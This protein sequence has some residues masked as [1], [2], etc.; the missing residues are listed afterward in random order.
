MAT[1]SGFRTVDRMTTSPAIE[2]RDAVCARDFSTV[3]ALLA[4][5]AVM[6][7]VL[8]PMILEASGRDEI[9]GWLIKWFADGDEFEV[10]DRD[11]ETIAGRTRVTWHFRF[12]THPVSG[13]AGAHDIEQT[14][15]CDVVGGR[16]TRIDLLCSGFRPVGV[17]IDG[18]ACSVPAR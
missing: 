3:G 2:L 17:V 9:V 18:P 10:L 8:P 11:D 7:G 1:G 5:D 4:D 6:R 14:A 13:A 16:I 12:G 15:F